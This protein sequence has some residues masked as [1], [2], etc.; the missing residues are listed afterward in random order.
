MNG[1]KLSMKMCE[2]KTHIDITVFQA[3]FIATD[4]L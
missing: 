2:G 1:Y 4:M 3:L